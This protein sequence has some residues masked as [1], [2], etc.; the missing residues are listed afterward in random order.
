MPRFFY[1]GWW[2]SKQVFTLYFNDWFYLTNCCNTQGMIYTQ[3][4]FV[5]PLPFYIAYYASVELLP[6]FLW[7][8][9]L[10]LLW[11][12]SPFSRCPCFEAHASAQC[13]SACLWKKCFL[14]QEKDYT[15]R[16]GSTF[17][18]LLKGLMLMPY[19]KK[20]SSCVL[21]LSNI[22]YTWS[23]KDQAETVWE[24]SCSCSALPY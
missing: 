17:L 7:R 12:P 9:N 4:Y 10:T 18:L 1:R 11:H 21:F 20:I 16:F 14:K 19:K 23:L 3:Y 5:F 24:I 13:V 8:H 2:F 22:I 6:E 15:C